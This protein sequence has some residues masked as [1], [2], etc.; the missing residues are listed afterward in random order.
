VLSDLEAAAEWSSSQAQSVVDAIERMAQG[1]VGWSL[2]RATDYLNLDVSYWQVAQLGIFYRGL[3][4]GQSDP[5]AAAEDRPLLM[6]QLEPE[7]FVFGMGRRYR[8]RGSLCIE[9]I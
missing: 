9:E 8:R 5:P 1:R 3:C 6:D 4:S 2:G 7:S